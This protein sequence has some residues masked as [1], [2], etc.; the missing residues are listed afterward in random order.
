MHQSNDGQ[1]YVG[2]KRHFYFQKNKDAIAILSSAWN[3]AIVLKP[4]N[5]VSGFKAS[6]LWTPSLVEMNKRWTL[7]HDGGVDAKKMILSLEFAHAKRSKRKSCPYPLPLIV[8]QRGG[9]H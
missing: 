4:Q 9:R 6:E 8:N 7:F 3:Q 1:V 2:E 5:I